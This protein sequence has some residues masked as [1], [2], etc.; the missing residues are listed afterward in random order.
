MYF[1]QLGETDLH[2]SLLHLGRSD[3]GPSV[4]AL[5]H[6]LVEFILEF[7]T[8][9]AWDFGGFASCYPQNIPKL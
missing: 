8:E 1:V 3:E 5:L 6:E 4:S 2:D 9:I 7:R